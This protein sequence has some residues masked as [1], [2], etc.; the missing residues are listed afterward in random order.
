MT[1]ILKNDQKYTI[2]RMQIGLKPKCILFI[3]C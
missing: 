2:K 3:V 1:L